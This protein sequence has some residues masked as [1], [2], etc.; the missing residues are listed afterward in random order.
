MNSTRPSQPYSFGSFELDP[1]A[2]E[3]R[4]QGR[5]IRLQGQ[6]LDILV[7]LLERRGEVVTREELQRRL[8]AA[9]TFVDFEHSLNAAVKR[10]R[11]ALDDSA[12]TPQF[13]ETLPRRGYRFI[14][15]LDGGSAVAPGGERRR[16]VRRWIGYA[17]IGLV[18]LVGVAFALNLGGWRDSVLHRSAASHIRSIAVL[19]LENLSGDPNQEYFADGM[20]DALITGLA[21][22]RALRVISRTSTLQYKRTQK[23]LS[24]IAHELNVDAV[25]EGTVLRDGERVRITAQLVDARTD[26]HLWAQNYERDLRDVLTLQADVTRSVTEEV[27]AQITPQE[28]ERLIRARRAVNPQA[29]E[30][31]LRGDSEWHKLTE[32]G[33]RKSA[34][35]YEEAIRLDPEYAAGHLGLATSYAVLGQQEILPPREAY[36]K[37]RAEVLKALELDDGLAEAHTVMGWVHRNYDWDWPGAEREF[38]RGLELNPGSPLVHHGYSAYLQTRGRLEESVAEER[39]AQEL[40]PLN[41]FYNVQLGL[42]L[43]ALGR[44]DEALAQCRRAAEFDPKHIRAHFC[45]GEVYVGQRKYEQAV[46]EMQKAV[47]L[48]KGRVDVV[49]SLAQVYILAGR[50]PEA[51]KLFNH[52]KALAKRRHISPLDIAYFYAILGQ[53]DEAFQWLE[54]AYQERSPF[55]VGIR[56]DPTFDSLRDDPRYISLLR[57]IG[58]PN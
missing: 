50:K 10:L 2:G 19:P 28:H 58:L 26:T 40:D 37:S 22:V 54:K 46:A 3:L 1:G 39:R 12:D 31:C 15:T 17:A 43:I 36:A 38:L 6:P 53:K 14:G 52:V 29:Y 9:D 24:K 23:S 32:Q 34:G 25:V 42:F 48:P 41:P 33:L 8:W 4:K 13:I 7:M 47:E 35:Y 55:I 49:A 57:R 16:L 21:Q 18:V 11:E 20:T 30:A 45:V 51:E 27:R 5:K 44:Y 56:L